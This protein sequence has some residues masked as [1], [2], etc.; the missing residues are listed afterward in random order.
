MFPCFNKN[1]YPIHATTE[2]TMFKVF[3]EFCQLNF[4]NSNSFLFFIYLDLPHFLNLLHSFFLPRGNSANAVSANFW[5]KQR[6]VYYMVSKKK[7]A[8][9][10]QTHSLVQT[11]EFNFDNSVTQNLHISNLGG[12]L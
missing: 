7:R 11:N 9:K 6:I 10:V 1:Y 8:S 4:P 2:T 12:A 5:M 3:L